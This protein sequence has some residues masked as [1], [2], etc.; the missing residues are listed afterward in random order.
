MQVIFYNLKFT[1]YIE[2]IILKYKLNKTSYILQIVL[3]NLFNTSYIIQV[4]LYRLF[5]TSDI[6]KVIS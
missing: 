2:L 6:I 5:Y 4:K 1:N 3:S